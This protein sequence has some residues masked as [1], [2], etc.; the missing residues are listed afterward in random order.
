M[1]IIGIRRP[2]WIHIEHH[3]S[4]KSMSVCDALYGL[5]GIV[6]TPRCGSTRIDPK[7]KKSILSSWTEGISGRI[8][9]IVIVYPGHMTRVILADTALQAE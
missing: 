8:I 4:I 3:K 7:A 6:E 2:L 9:S 1:H 5:D